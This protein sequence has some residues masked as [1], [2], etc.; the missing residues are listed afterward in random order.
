MARLKSSRNAVDHARARLK[1]RAREQLDSMPDAVEQCES[2]VRAGRAGVL[3]HRLH[4]T[5]L[6]EQ[7]RLEG[8]V[9]D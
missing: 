1:D 8:V 4:R 6:T 2:H 7:Q 3:G 9:H 5:L